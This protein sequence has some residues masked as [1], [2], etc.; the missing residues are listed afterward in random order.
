MRLRAAVAPILALVAT[1]AGAATWAKLLNGT[2]PALTRPHYAYCGSNGVYFVNDA[3]TSATNAVWR[4]QS[5]GAVSQYNYATTATPIGSTNKIRAIGCDSTYL[6][7]AGGGSENHHISYA[8]LPSLASWTN[9]TSGTSNVSWGGNIDVFGSLTWTLTSIASVD[10]PDTFNLRN[11][12]TGSF[13]SILTTSIDGYKTFEQLGCRVNSSFYFGAA[14]NDASSAGDIHTEA[15]D[16]SFAKLWDSSEATGQ[17]TGSWRAE[18]AY[19]CFTDS[20][21]GV[22][23]F[24]DTTNSQSLVVAQNSSGTK[25]INAQVI[26]ST[27]LRPGFYFDLDGSGA[28]LWAYDTAGHAYKS[29]GGNFATAP[30][31]DITLDGGDTLAGCGIGGDYDSLGASSDPFC[32]TTN[33][34]FFYA[35]SSVS[36]SLSPSPA[37]IAPGASSTLTW[38]C[39]NGTSSAN[40]WNA[41]T[42]ASGADSVSPTSSTGYGLRCKGPG[43]D[44]VCAT[45][46]KITVSA[47]GGRQPPS[48]SG[49]L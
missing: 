35:A 6:I 28:A 23:I 25:A 27:D 30:S 15:V 39:T 17:F 18:R 12:S 43:G 29:T 10:S 3:A 32:T 11:I 46:V 41:S 36:C 16:S 13:G 21:I 31:Y 8:A 19:P 24:Y 40:T 5:N 48:F 34:D 14:I 49:S 1:P 22:G 9:K 33:G 2:G 4:V 20:T 47:G 45:Q 44:A 26:T 7:G 38:S 42:G 37:T